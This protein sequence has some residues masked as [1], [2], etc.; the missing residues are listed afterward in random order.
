ML[1]AIVLVSISI[2]LSLR[3]GTKDKRFHYEVLSEDTSEENLVRKFPC[4]YMHNRTNE[5]EIVP[6]FQRQDTNNNPDVTNEYHER[7]SISIATM[8]SPSVA[9]FKR[10][11]DMAQR[12]PGPISVSVFISDASYED[13][14]KLAIQQLQYNNT[15]IFGSR[16]SFHLVTDL[17]NERGL[18][19]NLFPRNL[20][21]NVAIQ[22]ADA[23]Y[24]LLLDADLT[25]SKYAYKKLKTHLRKLEKKKKGAKHVVVVPA[26]EKSNSTEFKK[27]PVATKK[28]LLKIK[29]KQRESVL[30]FHFK[31][32]LI[33]HKNTRSMK[34]YVTKR[35]YSVTYADDYEPYVV[36]RKDA[37][38]PPFWEHFVG[39]GRNKLQWI[40]ELFVAGY[41]FTVVPD[42]FVLHKWHQSYGLRRVRPYIADEYAL[43]FQRYLKHYYGRSVR[44]DKSLD[45]YYESALTKWNDA[46]ASGNITT[47]VSTSKW[48][49]KLSNK[50]EVEFEQCLYRLK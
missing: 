19:K 34:W 31:S 12:W 11:K 1:A 29:K 32:K 45:V 9:L 23:N 17:K 35:D 38:L 43:R 25:P 28:E 42:V 37:N 10:L 36:V 4:H 6:H 26:F 22:N 2:I 3:L 48:F 41:K 20:L 44:S 49:S 46:V 16:I 13:Q 27:F 47:S 14:V 15:R 24:V 21:R 5:F 50:R 7:Y 33:A 30:P 39:F 18:D 40:E 8:I